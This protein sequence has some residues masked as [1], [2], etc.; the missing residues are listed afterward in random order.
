MLSKKLP[1]PLCKF[2][3]EGR[4]TAG[5]ACPYGATQAAESTRARVPSVSCP[6][7]AAARF[8]LPSVDGVPSRPPAATKELP[9]VGSVCER[10][11]ETWHAPAIVL[12]RLGIREDR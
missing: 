12:K 11:E 8:S 4:C 6:T 2:F 3:Q 9:A 5:D 1:T 10:T 7:M